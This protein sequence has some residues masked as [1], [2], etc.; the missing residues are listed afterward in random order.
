[1]PDI[2]P[3]RRA[4][5][6]AMSAAERDTFLHLQRTVRVASIGPDGA[7]HVTPLWFVWDGEHMWLNSLTRSQRWANLARNP[8]VAVVVDAGDG[9]AELHGVEL[10]GHVEPVG[11]QPRTGEPNPALDAVERLFSDKYF[12]GIPFAHDGR[13]AWLRITPEREYTWDFRKLGDL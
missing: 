6:I 5:R 8:R 10:S 2:A 3:Q 13:H 1:M 7:P 9:Y 4:R 12:D 11:E